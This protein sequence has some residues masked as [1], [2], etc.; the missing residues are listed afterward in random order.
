MLKENATLSP[1]S[2]SS[3]NAFVSWVIAK[4]LPFFVILTILVFIHEM[5]H[6]LVARR[7]GVKVTVFSIGF[8]PELFG[9]T[10]RH[11]TRWRFSLVPLGG[12]VK[13]LGDADPSSG[14][15]A[16]DGLSE[17]EK[18]QTLHSKTP[19]QR[20]AV[21]VAGPAANM[22]FAVVALWALIAIKGVPF[23]EPVIGK[24]EPGMLAEKSG[25]MVGDKIVKVDDASIED[26]HQLRHAITQSTGKDAVFQIERAGAQL[27]K[28]VSFYETDTATQE[29][30]TI[31]RLGIAPGE[32]HY[33]RHNPLMAAFYGLSLCWD[34]T[35][36]TINSLSRLVTGKSGSG[37][38]GGIL[39]IGDMAAQ[40]TKNGISS[41]I[42][43]MALLSINLGLINLLPIPVLDGG[44][45][46]LAGLEMVRGKPL[47]VK[48][49]EY[50]FLAGF[51]VV[52]AVMLYATWN[53]LLRY[54]VFHIIKSW[55]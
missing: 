38:L 51:L 49:Q 44:H 10:D 3:W 47:S 40:S 55:F 25:L 4:F 22:I 24:V 23:L 18:T 11:Q 52:A 8:G 53:D 30:K 5:G 32:P 14:R 42:W 34:L 16:D 15:S 20:M 12:Y 45:I 26:F 43:L 7:N 31:A 28:T 2:Y 41:V 21:A 54:K 19:L 17:E 46:L 1:T 37:E 6:F 39:S 48:A 36:E 27:T 9:W 33:V 50:I 13:M 35:V 29:K